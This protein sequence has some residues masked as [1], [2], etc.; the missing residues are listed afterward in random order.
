M[1]QAIMTSP[2]AIE[3]S[4][5]ADITGIKENEVLINIKR[6]GV[7]GSDIHVYHGKHPFTPFPV[8]QGHEYSGEVVAVGREVTK[9]KP[10][11]K[12]TGRP[13]LVCGVC[14]PC[15]AGRYN[16]CSNLKVEGFQA[17]GVARDY[18][19]L[20]EDRLYVAPGH[21]SF[22]EIA[23]IEPAAVAAHAIAKIRDIHLKNIVITGAGPIG[24]LVAQLAA[25]RGAKKVVVTDFNQFR[26]DLLASI[27]IRDVINLSRE[28]FD[29]GVKRVLNGEA[30]QTGIECVGAEA[31]LHNLVNHVEK[32]GEVIIVGV[33]EEHPR[34]N[35]GFVGEHELTVNG[36]MMYRHEDYEEALGFASEGKLQLK[37]L[38]T[39][40]FNFTDYK[41][42]YEYID[43]NS[44]QTLKVMI[45]VN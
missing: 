22:D 2:G 8:I 18:F 39:H 13:Q 6:I 35:M 41:K 7:C 15:K 9:T 25:I 30:F 20:P 27:G 4:E 44:A 34:L 36:S 17:P 29:D 11:D 38:I 37:P 31:A 3:I 43:A 19:V 24:N 10:G 1:K 40:R 42:A 16:V 5:V 23:M 12:V 21:V 32:G 28:S 33:Y 26:L 45:D 14:G